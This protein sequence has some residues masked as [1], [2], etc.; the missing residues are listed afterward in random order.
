MEVKMEHDIINTIR[1]LYKPIKRRNY[2]EGDYLL[3]FAEERTRELKEA[4]A[5]EVHN[6]FWTEHKS[7]KGNVFG[8]V[9]KE[10]LK[11][12]AINS[13]AKNGWLET[14]V[15]ILEIKNRDI[16]IKEFTNYCEK[17]FNHFILIQE[18]TTRAYLV[19]QYKI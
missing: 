14:S 5:I 4:G 15:N 2:Y 11:E 6:S 1:F 9:P 16:D 18:K 19:L 8:S 7:I 12:K 10:L 13:L 17:A 3:E